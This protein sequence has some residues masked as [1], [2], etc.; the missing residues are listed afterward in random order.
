[1]EESN[2]MKEYILLIET[3]TDI[4]SVAVCNQKKIIAIVTE[5]VIT[6][7]ISRLPIMIQNC[8]LQSQISFDDLVAIAISDGP[9]SYTSLRVGAATVKGICYAK[10]IPLIKINTL[11]AIANG[12]LQ[13]GG[14]PT[15]I[16]SMIDAR[17]ME[18]YTATFDSERNMIKNVN[19]LIWNESFDLN[20][21]QQQSIFCGNG[22]EKIYKMIQN[23]RPDIRLSSVLD[24]SAS[25]LFEI[26]VEKYINNEFENIHSYSPSYFKQPNITTSKKNII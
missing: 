2:K 23:D 11:H 26:A 18:V 8:L 19:S 5:L 17:R 15:S 13:L 1:M 22:A 14:I 3:A 20:Y 4:C 21:F 9:G 16:V 25:F 6:K 7:H 10:S 24:C 12:V